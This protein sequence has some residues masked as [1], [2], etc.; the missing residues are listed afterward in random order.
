MPNVVLQVNESVMEKFMWL[1]GHFSKEEII[2][3]DESFLAAKAYL[4]KEREDMEKGAKMID[5]KSFWK[6]TEDELKAHE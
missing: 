1:L 4:H 3:R 2:L 5:E 6:S